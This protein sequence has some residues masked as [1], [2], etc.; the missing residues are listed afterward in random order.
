MFDHSLH[1]SLGI[2]NSSPSFVV[3]G[4]DSFSIDKTNDYDPSFIQTFVPRVTN[5]CSPLTFRGGV[6]TL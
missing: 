6:I 4:E 1:K 3:G 2:P 5:L